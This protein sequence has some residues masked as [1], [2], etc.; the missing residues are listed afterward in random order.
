MKIR[1]SM[2]T[3]SGKYMNETG[4]Y[5]CLAGWVT[6]ARKGQWNKS[7]LLYLLIAVIIA[8]CGKK[9]GEVQAPEFDVS[10]GSSVYKAGDP[11]TFLFSGNI[12]VNL[13]LYSGETFNDYTFK[14]GRIVDISGKGVSVG[15]S[16]AYLAGGSQ[17]NQLSLWV[18]NNYN[19]KG[20]TASIKA[21]TWQNVTSLFNIATTTTRV[22]TSASLSDYFEPGKPLFFAFK[23]RTLPQQTN[24]ITKALTIEGFN[25]TSLVPDSITTNKLIY[26]Q[27]T[28]GF[29]IT[30]ATFPLQAPT[31][32]TLSSTT[33]RLMGNEYKNPDDPIYNPDNP[34]YN[35]ENP[36]YDPQNPAYIPGAKVPVYVPYDPGSPYNDPSTEVWVISK[37]LYADNLNY[38]TDKPIPIKGITT[39]SQFREYQYTYSK[40]GNY[41]AVIVGTNH[42]AE[43]EQSV[44]K[45]I[46]IEITQ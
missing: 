46:M 16:S 31:R 12:P 14:D 21:A 40:P 26:S 8:S 2:F 28:A 19:G 36:I 18:S 20:D 30:D 17:T 13:A 24:G 1:N 6:K 44:V 23:Y 15:F 37:P 42:N 25:V 38:G 32:T 22:T 10:T 9:L 4:R 11:V 29:Y 34:I 43:E 41:E 27:A 5:R 33:I 39:N 3:Y 45:K 7:V 35:P